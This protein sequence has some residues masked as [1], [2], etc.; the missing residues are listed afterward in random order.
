[1]WLVTRHGFFSIVKHRTAEDCYLVRA[2]VADDLHALA[3]VTG[4]AL[5]ILATPD[6]DYGHRA[7][8]DGA[9]LAAI[10]TTLGEEIDY[11]NFKS[12]VNREPAQRRR[13]AIY[14]AAYGE[15]LAL[16]DLDQTATPA[17]A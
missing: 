5:D 16:R 13:Y 10:L 7:F 3:R 6:A 11:P 14:S 8:V 4:L 2:R 9:E 15:L 17:T 1:M 12:R